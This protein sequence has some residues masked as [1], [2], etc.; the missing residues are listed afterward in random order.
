MQLEVKQP[1]KNIMYVVDLINPYVVIVSIIGLIFEY[2]KLSTFPPLI[3]FNQGIDVYFLL[4]FIFRMVAYRSS[5][6]YFLKNY[7]WV[8]M[9]A[10][11]PGLMVPIERILGTLR[12]GNNLF[13]IIKLTRV[14]KFFKMIRILRFMRMFSFLK[15]MRADSR[16][17]QDRLMKIGVSTVLVVLVGLFFIDIMNSDNL[18]KLEQ[19]KIHVYL[20]AAGEE[21]FFYNIDK[22]NIIAYRTG[23]DYKKIIRQEQEDGTIQTKI[24]DITSHQYSLLL[25]ENYITEVTDHRLPDTSIALNTQT[26]RDFH[27]SIML[28]LV[29]T[30]VILL[31]LQ[32][33]YIGFVMAKD[34]RVVQLIID[35]LEADDFFLLNEEKRQVEE[36]YGTLEVKE[37]EDEIL[38]LRKVTGKIGEKIQELEDREDNVSDMEYML[39]VQEETAKKEKMNI[40]EAI[41]QTAQT[42]YNRLKSDVADD[43]NPSEEDEDNLGSSLE[44]SLSGFSDIAGLD[45]EESEDSEELIKITAEKIKEDIKEYWESEGITKISKKII[46]ETINR[47]LPKIKQYLEKKD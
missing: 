31:L 20:E 8:D 16:Y 38:S 36:E 17:I 14:G 46:A 4:E 3:F 47:L 23:E 26:S 43:K 6:K 44:D 12:V 41:D 40:E 34:I 1:F 15:K 45:K 21:E 42:I 25:R 9:L 18:M 7:G 13:G 30:L 19:E 2:T 32:L 33:F 22:F 35:S 5:K 11:I 29:L 10:A 37:G 39:S 24:I 28:T 27:N